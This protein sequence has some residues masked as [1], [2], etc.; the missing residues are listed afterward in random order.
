M[1]EFAKETGKRFSLAIWY[2]KLAYNLTLP[3]QAKFTK[4]ETKPKKRP[5]R[6]AL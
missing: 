5:S 1:T 4:N 6:E 3:Q 2:A